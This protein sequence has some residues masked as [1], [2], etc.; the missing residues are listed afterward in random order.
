MASDPGTVDFILEQLDGAGAVR[1]RK[2][3]GEY[4]VYLDDKVIALVCDDTLFVK[5]TPGARAL[6]SDPEEAPPYPGAKPHLVASALLDEPE[7]LV[8]LARA[9]WADLPVPKPKKPRKPKKG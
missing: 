7:A 5:N 4:A 6:L 1:A 3:F 9:A 8:A 2:M